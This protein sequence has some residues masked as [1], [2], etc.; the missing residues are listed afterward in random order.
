MT[1]KNS[2]IL[3]QL[4]PAR[5][6]YV[7][8]CRFMSNPKVT[9][10]KLIKATIDTT[11]EIV[12]GKDVLVL[13][14]TSEINYQDHTAQ[15]KPEDPDLGPTGN[16]KDIGFFLHPGYVI[17]EKTGIGLGFSYINLWN[18]RFDK[19]D[20]YERGYDSQPIEEKESHRWIECGNQS[21]QQLF[22][23][24][25]ITIIAD[26]EGDI[27]QEFVQVPNKKVDLLIRS[28]TNRVLYNK[29]EKL[30]ES[31]SATE[32]KGSFMLDI[33]K[34]QGRK[35]RIAAIELRYEKV[36]IQRPASCID[37]TLPKYIELNIVQVKETQKSVPQGEYPIC[38][39]LLTTLSVVTAEN[40]LEI[41]KKY[42][43]RWEIE[44]LFGT[45]K[46]K[47]LNVE[48]SQ[49]ETGRSLK[50]LCVLAMVSALRIMQLRQARSVGNGLDARI[51]FTSKE[52]I[53]L[54]ALTK[55]YEGKT[56]KQKNP[57]INESLS[58]AAWTIARVGGW[59]GY[60]CESPPG[61]KTF[62][63]GLTRFDKIFEGYQLFAEI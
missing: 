18:R 19:L 35:S 9:S 22:K 21:K 20:K 62:I 34:H 48:L 57:Y 11:S 53:V 43:S 54:A 3:H 36:Q 27:Y 30:Y 2:A 45:M 13:Q 8:F 59:K 37:K 52:L 1:R 41:V 33:K 60:S 47:G 58:W 31:V 56:K 6:D 61:F 23:A 28:S 39:H 29:K 55:K 50:T 14:D 24:N 32:C 42:R 15:F 40:A 44:L 51:A 7:G 38:W 17:D 16:N 12:E 25:H 5:S 63:L 10:G 4:S 26:R 46:S 49:L